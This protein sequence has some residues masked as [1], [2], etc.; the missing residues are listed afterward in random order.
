M[1]IVASSLSIG[2]IDLNPNPSLVKNVKLPSKAIKT[3]IKGMIVAN[4]KS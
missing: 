2:L 4:I 1:D 3:I